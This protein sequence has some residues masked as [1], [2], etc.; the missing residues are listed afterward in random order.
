MESQLKSHNFSGTSGQKVEIITVNLVLGLEKSFPTLEH[1]GTNSFG[2]IHS[3]SRIIRINR[4]GVNPNFQV[5]R[6]NIEKGLD[7]GPSTG[8]RYNY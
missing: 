7:S 8:I 4:Q 5:L 6:L 1:L 2:D 3:C